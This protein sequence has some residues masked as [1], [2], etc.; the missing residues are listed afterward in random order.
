MTDV[1]QEQGFALVK[2]P[3]HHQGAWYTQPE[4]AA[5]YES[6]YETK[7]QVLE[8]LE[9]EVLQ[10]LL[11]RF[12]GATSMADVGCGTAHFT[13]WYDSLGYE[14]VGV[15]ISPVMLAEARKHW[16]G[17][18]YN[19]QSEDLPFEDQSVDLVSMISCSAYMPDLGAVLR[20]TGR[21][22]RK[23]II[24]GLMNKWSLPTIRRM[25]QV[26]L[27]QNPFYTNA[28]FRSPGDV[29]R[30]AAA[31]FR[32]RPFRFYWVSTGFPR[33]FYDRVAKLPLG[34]F[35]GVAIRFETEG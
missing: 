32:D 4:I 5:G 7:Y 9:K 22:A 3:E 30:I 31:T 13:R 17:K 19:A 29:K 33:P 2:L 15:D 16:N 14:T 1:Q 6:Y 18:L 34:S 12:E 8:R 11:D 27:G 20:E 28:T 25:I 26:K 21:V 24:L 10:R 23:G 35:A